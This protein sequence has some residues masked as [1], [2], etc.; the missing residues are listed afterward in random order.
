MG[1]LLSPFY[2]EAILGR[3]YPNGLLIELSPDAC[4]FTKEGQLYEE[5]ESYKF[6]IFI[7]EYW[8]YLQ[9]FSTI[10]G[11]FSY[12]IFQFFYAAFTHTLLVNK[13]GMSVGS[14]GL[15]DDQRRD[16]I[17]FCE[18][19]I[20]HEGSCKGKVDANFKDIKKI[21]IIISKEDANL[22]L[23]GEKLPRKRVILSFKIYNKS[24]TTYDSFNYNLG[25]CAIY[26]GVA[27]EIANLI[28]N[29]S[30][31]SIDKEDMTSPVFPYL[32]LRIL[33]EKYLGDISARSIIALGTFCLLTTNPADAL[34]FMLEDFRKLRYHGKADQEILDELWTRVKINTLQSI[35]Q[36]LYH[37]LQSVSEL[38]EGRGIIEKALLYTKS[39]FERL[40][41][42][43]TIDPLYD[44]SPFEASITSFHKIGILLNDILPCTIIQRNEGDENIIERDTLCVAGHNDNKL[45]ASLLT[46]CCQR[47][48]MISHLDIK[49][50]R[51]LNSADV[52]PT[53]CPFYTICTVRAQY[54]NDDACKKAPWKIYS[55]GATRS[56]NYGSAVASTL[57]KTI[58]SIIL[59]N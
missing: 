10:A 8:H 42:R 3:Y 36:I 28:S 46:L 44:L 52:K 43:R 41:I 20:N 37:D 23:R 47:H 26:E 16:I 54:N 18:L 17:E 11:A 39:L 15:Q 4:I 5:I 1:N 25:C 32:V 31:H 48:Y 55:P 35:D 14:D 33:S 49:N 27:S 7:H 21:D 29:N 12:L 24:G 38:Y 58:S 50:Q 53:E 40:I 30:H 22:M 57:G 9:N 2:D 59:E 6:A 45:N 13:D 34:I 56:C 19:W 51:F